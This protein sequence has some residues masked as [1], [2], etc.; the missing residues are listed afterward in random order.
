MLE[1]MGIK[2]FFCDGNNVIDVYK[3]SNEAVNFIKKG[4]GP[5]FI[6]FST[7]RWLEHCGP[8]YDN[9]LGYRT[10]KEFETWKKKDPILNFEKYLIKSGFKK[11]DI[12]NIEKKLKLEIDNAFKYAEKSKFP[13]PHYAFQDLFFK[14]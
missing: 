3:T 11:E 5:V 6:E 9:D 14:K 13:K 4:N 10:I 2:T 8:N 7:Y 1:A 12:I